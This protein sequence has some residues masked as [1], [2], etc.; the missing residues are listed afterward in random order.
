MKRY[1]FAL[2]ALALIWMSVYLIGKHTQTL[3]EEISAPLPVRAHH[4][5][6]GLL[7]AQAHQVMHLPLDNSTDVHLRLEHHIRHSLVATPT[8]IHSQLF[9][10]EAQPRLFQPQQLLFTVDSEI[11]LNGHGRSV[12]HL[13]SFNAA[14]HYLNWGEGQGNVVFTPDHSTINATLPT[15]SWHNFGMRVTATDMNL[16]HSAQPSYHQGE[17]SVG[18]LTQ[19]SDSNKL[20][21]ASQAMI[22][23]KL[24]PQ[25]HGLE[26]N[27]HLKAAQTHWGERVYQHHGVAFDL[28][29]KRLQPEHIYPLL[30]SLNQW[31]HAAPNLRWLVLIQVFEQAQKLLHSYPEI[32]IRQLQVYNASGSPLMTLQLNFNSHDSPLAR[33]S[34]LMFWHGLD[35]ELQLT[36][37]MQFLH[38]IIQNYHVHI[39]R[40]AAQTP[41][42]DVDAQVQDYIQA[43]VKRLQEYGYL[44]LNPPNYLLK[45]KFSQGRWQ[46]PA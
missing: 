32:E 45:L 7:Q 31:Q 44:S 35:F 16:E 34:P 40:A 15:L 12:F 38:D 41:P 9:N 42:P 1:F 18:E 37:E 29:L 21:S 36:V 4:Y 19:Y 24:H 14:E 6:R 23:W 46:P 17:L 28:S 11:Q 5:Q 8:H 2:S 25:A 10:I 26:L 3:F 33:Q 22:T 30:H 20:F 13:P 39:Y 43:G 27:T